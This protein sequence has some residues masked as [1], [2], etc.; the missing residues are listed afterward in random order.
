MIIG[1][2]LEW[3]REW[4]DVLGLAFDSGEKA[5]ATARTPESLEQYL[6]VLKAADTVVM[7]NGIDADC[8]QLA[9]E[10]ID[11]S[12]LEPK[13][14]DIRLAFHCIN[15]HL[16]GSGSFDLRSIVLLLGSKQGIRFPLEFKQ[17]ESDLHKTCAMDAAAALWCHSTL[18]RQIKQHGLERTLGIAHKC[19]PIF[20]RMREQ[21]VRLDKGVLEQIYNA[22]KAKTEDR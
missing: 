6:K 17:Y 10:G 5:A 18:D 13:V 8:R 4:I 19:A 20:T 7:Q 12:W 14:Y 22:R 1:S 2:D 15:G 11:V 21:G 16:A 9:S 3:T